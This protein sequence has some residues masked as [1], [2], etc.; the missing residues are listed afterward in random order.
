MA[1]ILKCL[2]A[3]L[4]ASLSFVAAADGVGAETSG[5]AT[6]VS[7]ADSA[8]LAVEP[9]QRKVS[10]QEDYK[11]GSQDLLE[12]QVFQSEQ[13]SRTV[14][15]N[16]KGYV[17]LPLIGAIMAGGLSSQELETLIAKKLGET[18]MQDPQV[19]VFIKEY[20]SQRVTIEGYVKSAGIYPLK[21]RTSLVQAVA[22]A[23]GLDSLADA[24]E[25]RVF[26]DVKG[27]KTF[28]VYNLE[29]IRSGKAEDPVVQ[30]DDIIV[31]EGSSSKSFIKG[32]TDTIRGFIRPF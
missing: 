9:P 1:M 17:S 2:M 11:I 5:S 30:G 21:G 29:D 32:V 20:T 3:M 22:M 26:R 6:Q 12:I 10:V 8:Q 14:R 16:S 23:S 19:S 24:A 18:Y 13:M 4:C 31:V 27:E 25:I 7:L 28:K 15:V